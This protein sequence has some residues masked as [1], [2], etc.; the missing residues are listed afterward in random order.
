M[1]ELL[2]TC[3]REYFKGVVILWHDS[4]D[5]LY[6]RSDILDL[7][8]GDG[9][10]LRRMPYSNYMTNRV[11]WLF[12]PTR[13]QT[14]EY[15]EGIKKI[16]Y[17]SFICEHSSYR[18]TLIKFLKEFLNEPIP[19]PDLSSSFYIDKTATKKVKGYPLNLHCVPTKE[20]WELIAIPYI[21][22]PI[23]AICNSLSIS[24]A[25]FRDIMQTSLG[26]YVSFKGN[27]YYHYAWTD[28][29]WTLGACY[30]VISE[31]NEKDKD[32]PWTLAIEAYLD[33]LKDMTKGKSIRLK[34]ILE[35]V[36][37]D[38]IHNKAVE[39]YLNIKDTLLTAISYIACNV[40][41]IDFVISLPGR[42]EFD[43]VVRQL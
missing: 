37:E 27:T 16:L 19:M 4:L 12:Y 23:S 5:G 31:L 28:S 42:K 6:I 2:R 32:H 7:I 3:K 40:S 14:K 11:Y 25:A 30:M 43:E 39:N 36:S 17:N 8:P 38:S 29:E 13:D 35:D 24:Q 41:T 10:P 18:A 26:H 15:T 1:E 9:Y 21:S 34:P 33:G 22:F 20:H